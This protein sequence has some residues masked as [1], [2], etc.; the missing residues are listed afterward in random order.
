MALASCQYPFP[1]TC[2]GSMQPGASRSHGSIWG[3]S[4][5]PCSA[6]QAGLLLAAATSSI[7][8]STDQTESDK[9]REGGGEEREREGE[10]VSRK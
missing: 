5:P 1:Y 3:R 2:W 8:C 9:R 6:P 4:Q 7:Y 10:T